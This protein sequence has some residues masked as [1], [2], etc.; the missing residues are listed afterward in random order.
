MY[1]ALYGQGSRSES[2]AS[3]GVADNQSVCKSPGISKADL[4]AKLAQNVLRR[5][6]E[7]PQATSCKTKARFPSGAH[8]SLAHTQQRAGRSLFNGHIQDGMGHECPEVVHHSV[9][10][11]EAMQQVTRGLPIEGQQLFLRQTESIGKDRHS[12]MDV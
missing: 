12:G 10:D 6:E 7:I 3:S 8:K 2:A 4:Y 9:C 1:T 11:S 5:G